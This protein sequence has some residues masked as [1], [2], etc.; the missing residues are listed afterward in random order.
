MK[1]MRNCAY[2]AVGVLLSL[3][4]ATTNPAR[5][6]SDPQ[7]GNVVAVPPNINLFIYYNDV[8]GSGTVTTTNGTNLNHT[9]LALDANVFRY[10]HTMSI[11]GYVAGTDVVVPIVSYLGD[12]KVNGEEVP[13]KSGFGQ[14]NFGLVFWPINQPKAGNYILLHGWISPPISS[15]SKITPLTGPELNPANNVLT[16]DI[17]IGARTR[18]FGSQTTPNVAIEG[19]YDAYF[20]QNNPNFAAVNLP[21]PGGFAPA[22][23]T[24]REQPTQELR[25]YLTYTFEPRIGAFGAVGFYQSFGGKQ[26]LRIAGVP[27]AIDTGN[28]TNESQLRFFLTSFVSPSVQAGIYLYYDIAAHG[29]PEQRVLGLR[30][31]KAF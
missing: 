20:Y 31:V 18:L 27:Q 9:R 21:A 26:T 10:I 4:L 11:G 25:A 23:V 7:A 2:L 15:F 17:E 28:R 22:D 12:Q 6:V 5:A 13:H 19:W 3:S 29:G 24:F 16:E 8:V 30:V 14:P 1:S